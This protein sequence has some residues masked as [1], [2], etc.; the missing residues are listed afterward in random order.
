M[1]PV[2]PP[3]TV[4]SVRSAIAAMAVAFVMAAFPLDAHAACTNPAGNEGMIIFNDEFSTLQ[5]C[6]DTN[7]IAMDGRDNTILK[8]KGVGDWESSENDFLSWTPGSAASSNT[9]Q[10]FSF[11]I[12][13]ESAGVTANTLF[14]SWPGGVA[15]PA[16]WAVIGVDNRLYIGHTAASGEQLQL[17]TGGYTFSDTANWHHVLI[18]FDMTQSVLTNKIR[19]WVD[20]ASTA[21][22]LVTGDDEPMTTITSS[23]MNGS[24]QTIGAFPGSTIDDFDGLIAEFHAIDGGL[25]PV[26]AFYSSGRALAYKGTYGNNGFYLKFSDSSN[27]GRDYSGRGNDFT[28]SGVAHH[29]SSF[30]LSGTEPSGLVNHWTLDSIAGNISADVAGGI[31]CTLSGTRSVVAGRRGMA[32][33]LNNGF[34]ACG[35]GVN[36]LTSVSAFSLTGWVR[37][38]APGQAIV[39]GKSGTHADSTYMTL[40]GDGNIWVVVADSPPGTEEG[41]TTLNDDQWH[42]VAMVFDGTLSGNANRLKLYIDGVQATLS[43]G[44]TIP[45]VTPANGALNFYMGNSDSAYYDDVRVY[46]R[47]LTPLEVQAIMGLCSSPSGMPGDIIYSSAIEAV[48]YCNGMS[49][50]TISPQRTIPNRNNLV[51]HYKFEHTSGTTLT[52]HAGGHTGT[53]SNFTLPAAW[54]TG[55]IGANALNFDGNDDYVSLASPGDFAFNGAGTYTWAMWINPDDFEEWNSLFGMHINQN[56]TPTFVID[57]HTSADGVWGPVTAGIVVGIDQPGAVLVVPSNN[58]VLTTG[59]W[60][61]VT[62]TYDG[63][64]PIA[65]RFTIYVNG[66]DV[67]STDV[68]N[69]APIGNTTPTNVRLGHNGWTGEFFDGRMDDF[70]FYTRVLSEDE[71]R[72]LAA[73]GP[74]PGTCASP[75][76]NAGMMIYNNTANVVQFCN[77]KDWVAAG[78]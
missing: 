63:A 38:S 70:R 26:S 17:F 68:Y 31:N 50:A 15:I 29:I 59:T 25:V 28:N 72:A 71:I 9:Q 42:H 58:N 3:K 40:T 53:L 22:G 24:E 10:T 64:L 32:T 19:L 43:Y 8:I 76:G 74:A 6:D 36:A 77:G 67:T 33:H 37:R 48:Q 51:A 66:V 14:G 18:Q 35:T 34:S 56:T 41:Y 52:D 20:G 60:S 46:N 4:Q 75:A 69:T 54:T 49:W 78:R 5:F 1:T 61:H 12:K 44:G 65:D 13:R 39:I 47:A 57:A 30:P 27:L 16:S 62:V 55:H 21:L 73:Y 45:A 23:L 7:W 11:W 2:L